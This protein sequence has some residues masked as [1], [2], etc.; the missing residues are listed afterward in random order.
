MDTEG[1]SNIEHRTSNIE[2]ETGNWKLETG[3]WKL[4]TYK[5]DSCQ[6]VLIRG[7]RFYESALILVNLWMA[8]LY[9]S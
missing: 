1:T 8:Y 5:N 7:P 9:P 2:L 3:N 6:F 4:E